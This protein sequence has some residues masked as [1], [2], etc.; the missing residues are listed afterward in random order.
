LH[1][2]FSFSVGHRRWSLH[3]L[4]VPWFQKNESFRPSSG[5]DK[6]RCR[7]TKLVDQRRRR[8]FFGFQPPLVVPNSPDLNLPVY[9]PGATTSTGALEWRRLSHYIAG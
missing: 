3:P 2:R 4:S 9:G 5:V 6:T 8:G 1:V 7:P